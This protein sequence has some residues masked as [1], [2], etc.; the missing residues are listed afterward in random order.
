MY[1]SDKDI[2]QYLMTQNL[3]ENFDSANLGS[4]SYD[5]R[6]EKIIKIDETQRELSTY[7]LEPGETVFIASIENI[8]LPNNCFGIVVP[9]NSCIRMGLSIV[10]PVFH[11]GHHTKVFIR[12]TNISQ[13]K[14]S[15]KSNTSIASIMFY[16][17]NQD[18]EHPYTGTFSNE[19]NYQGVGNFHSTSIP[20]IIDIKEKVESIK[21]IEKNMYSN[22]IILMTIFIGIFS[23]I[24]INSNFLD[25]ST[26]LKNMLIYNFIFLGGI[27]TLVTLI[28]LV[29]PKSLTSKRPTL[30]LSIISTILIVVALAIYVL[31]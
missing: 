10:A 14:I 24:N 31:F 20:D 25:N 7:I 1:L 19:F 16:V 4:V 22:V 5:L 27:S 17:L 12:V 15:L 11:P 21:D 23:L 3:I 29:V 9:R 30:I 28:S 26:Q 18:V 2:R 13:N 6:V 8:K